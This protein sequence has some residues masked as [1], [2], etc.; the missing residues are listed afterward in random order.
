MSSDTVR[1]TTL[2]LLYS[3]KPHLTQIV[4]QP[5]RDARRV[6]SL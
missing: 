3:N 1:L 6:F 5:A 4:L 2:Y